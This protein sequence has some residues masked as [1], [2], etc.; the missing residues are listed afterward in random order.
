LTHLARI[1]VVFVVVFSPIVYDIT[2][3]ALSVS[4]DFG[5][6]GYRGRNTK[7]ETLL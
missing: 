1:I 6:V 2:S 4:G 5:V 7:L 3:L